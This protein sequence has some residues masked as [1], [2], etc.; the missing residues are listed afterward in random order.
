LQS[1][2]DIWRSE[3]TMGSSVVARINFRTRETCKK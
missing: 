1:V 3:N 2:K